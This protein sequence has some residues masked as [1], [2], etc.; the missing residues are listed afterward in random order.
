MPITAIPL[1]RTAFGTS[2]FP[3]AQAEAASQAVDLF[4]QHGVIGVMALAFLVLLLLFWRADKR[5]QRYAG[6][7]D[8]RDK[9]IEALIAELTKSHVNEGLLIQVI[10]ANTAAN[11]KL[12]GQFVAI[13]ENQKQATEINRLL[14]RRLALWQCPFADGDH[15]RN[16]KGVSA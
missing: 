6:S 13:A 16:Y 9:H 8:N 7:L 15:P 14:E 5:A 12:A 2:L 1:G 4:L 10:Q 11:D 3:L